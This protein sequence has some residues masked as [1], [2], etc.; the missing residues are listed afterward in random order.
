MKYAAVLLVLLVPTVAKADVMFPEVTY[1]ATGSPGDFTLD[2]S[3][4]N[5]ADGTNNL[6]FF[7][8]LLDGATVSGVPAGWS[9]LGPFDV[10]DLAGNFATYNL[11]WISTDPHATFI[12]PGGTL[13]GF[14]VHLTSQAVPEAILWFAFALGGTYDGT[15][16]IGDPRNPGFPGVVTPSGSFPHVPEPASMGLVGLGLCG[17]V[18]G[19]W[20]VMGRR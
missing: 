17:W 11:T 13:G 20:R 1:T 7:G 18:A 14:R 19:R 16:F 6:Y 8:V 10:P 5:H 12:P 9:E 15:D 4:T 2:F 3:L